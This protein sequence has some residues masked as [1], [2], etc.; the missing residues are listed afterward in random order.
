M[1]RKKRKVKFFCFAALFLIT[2]ISVYFSS[3]KIVVDYAEKTFNS[4]ISSASYH[5]VDFIVGEEYKYADLVDIKKDAD[6]NISM[7]VTNSL[8][9][10]RLATTAA[11]KAF[12]FL[13]EEVEKGVDVPIGAFTGVRLASGFGKK[14]KMKVL[15]M[16]SVKCDFI[17]E[18]NQAGINQ[19]RH[20]LYLN[21]NC[22]AD[23]VTKTR[24]KVIND[25]ITILV[26]D[27]LIV[28]KVPK[29]IIN[30]LTL[31]KSEIKT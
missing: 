24:T 1:K 11:T 21:I 27:N 29:A 8:E 22:E 3:D 7:I 14:V 25:K 18:F 26:F 30:P 4:L 10:N 12:D 17:S 16:A 31:G 5:A 28:G 19:T 9:V 20:S 23:V 6:G 15:G 13:Y 2:V